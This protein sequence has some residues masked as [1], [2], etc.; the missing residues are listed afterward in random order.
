MVRP[1]PTPRCGDLRSRV[2][3]N[4]SQVI[5]RSNLS[6]TLFF[7]ISNPF[8][9]NLQ[10]LE[11]LTPYTNDLNQSM[12]KEGV[13]THTI[14]QEKQH[15]T[16]TQSKERTVELAVASFGCLAHRTVR[17]CHVSTVDYAPT[18][19]A[20]ESRWPPGSLESPVNYNKRVWPISQE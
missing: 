15:H 1:M 9:R 8:V 14:L 17:C 12:S 7:L 19:G 16:H 5:Q 13:E 6:A 18:V 3:L 2:A 10:K 20:G 4:P 11:S